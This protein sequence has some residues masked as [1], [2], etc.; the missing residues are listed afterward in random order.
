MTS[1]EIK[2]LS[3]SD[4]VLPEDQRVVLKETLGE[5]VEGD[6]PSSY[7]GKR[8]IIAV[9]DVVTDRLLEQGVTPDVSIVDGKTRR[10]PYESEKPD[11]EKRINIKNPAGMITVESWKAVEKALVSDKPVLIEVTGE[12]DMLSLVAI[13]LCPEGGIVIYGY[14]E[15]GMVI[16]EVDDPMKKRTLEALNKMKELDDG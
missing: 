9:G 13:S 12:E 8:P 7:I 5:L 15:K 14:P 6:L 4:L 3:R 2:E 10:G 1:D 16:N 11:I